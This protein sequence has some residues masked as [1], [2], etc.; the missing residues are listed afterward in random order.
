MLK[1]TWGKASFL[2]TGDI[3]ID[4]EEA[5][6][7]A[8]GGDGGLRSVML[9]VPHHGAATSSS[10]AFLRAVQPAIAVVSVGEDNRFGHP[11]AAALERLGDALL[12]RTDQH[13][14][15]RLSTDGERLWVSVERVR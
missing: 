1:L 13:G 3:E 6:L 8:D 5:L 12:L 10:V 11:S 14:T 15:V 2:L 4:G 9:K 7:A